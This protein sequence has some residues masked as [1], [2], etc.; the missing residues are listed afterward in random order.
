MDTNKMREQFEQAVVELYKNSDLHK[1]PD[2]TY[3]NDA[4][5]AAWWGWKAYRETLV[6]EL[7]AERKIRHLPRIDENQS[8]NEALE[9]CR[10]AI[11]AQGLKVKP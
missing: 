11:E 4:I 7:P 2:G 1:K 3:R 9:N 5:Q 8:Y 10:E 6:V